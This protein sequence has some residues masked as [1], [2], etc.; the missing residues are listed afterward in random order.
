[1]NKIEYDIHGKQ[2][3]V[4]APSAVQLFAAVRYIRTIDVARRF[5][6]AVGIETGTLV[7]V[8]AN[9]GY[10]SYMMREACP[11]A[12]IIAFEPSQMNRD[13]IHVNCSG[14]ELYPYAVYSENC[15]LNLSSPTAVQRRFPDSFLEDNTGLLSVYGKG[16][17]QEHVPAIKIDE[18]LYNKSSVE[19]IKLDIEGAEIDALIGAGNSIMKHRPLIACEIREE[20][21]IMA[22]YS[23]E[24]LMET[25]MQMGYVHYGKLM[26]DTLFLPKERFDY[27]DDCLR[28]W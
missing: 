27:Y 15:Y 2:Y 11:L 17:N 1:M 16:G 3:S 7:D 18:V 6:E 10:Y 24:E 4:R 9:V 19:F 26:D 23:A 13:Y 28:D 5:F 22:G 25:I 14:I 21:Q 20:N 8:G 12:D